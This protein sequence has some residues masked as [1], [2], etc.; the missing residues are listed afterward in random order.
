MVKINWM[1]MD[2]A[3]PSFLAMVLIPFTHSISQGIIWGF[4]SWAVLKVMTGKGNTVSPTL[5]VIVAFCVLALV[6]QTH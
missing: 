2:E 3:I 5:W 6:M 1:K 4:I